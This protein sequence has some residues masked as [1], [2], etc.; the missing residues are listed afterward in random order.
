ME[1]TRAVQTW[2]LAVESVS[3]DKLPCQRWY[4]V[5]Q[6]GN[7]VELDFHLGAS[8]TNSPALM[9]CASGPSVSAASAAKVPHCTTHP[10]D[11]MTATCSQRRIKAKLWVTTSVVGR[12]GRGAST[13]SAKS[14]AVVASKAE[15]G[16]SSNKTG[17]LRARARA[18]DNRWRSPPDRSEPPLPTGD[19]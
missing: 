4:K 14:A 3:T 2:Y 5:S 17:A 7:T 15:V 6:V 18:K 13:A 9:I 12:F 10:C 19:M 11:E 16:S 8:S 1:I